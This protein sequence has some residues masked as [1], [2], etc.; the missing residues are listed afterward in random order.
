MSFHPRKVGEG[1]VVREFRDEDVDDIMEMYSL[2]KWPIS[3]EGMKSWSRKSEYTRVLVAERNGKAVGKVTFD[4]AYP[5]YSELVNLVVHPNYRRIGIG[6]RLIQSC[7][8]VAHRKR[9]SIISAMANPANH[10]AHRLYSKFGF[11]I[12]ILPDSKEGKMWLFRF[13]E[14]PPLGKFLF[15]HP[16]SQ[17]SVSPHKILFHDHPLYEMKWIDPMT[18]D[19]MILYLEGQPGQPREGGTMPRIAGI[20]YKEGDMAL[21]C[22]VHEKQKLI[23]L[24]RE[25]LFDLRIVNAG[26]KDLRVEGLEFTL[27][28]GSKVL[29]KK[30][31]PRKLRTGESK[32]VKLKFKLLSNFD[33]PTLSF[34]TILATSCLKFVGTETR[35]VIT[36]GF[37]RVYN[38]DLP[39][40]R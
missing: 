40:K 2:M 24:E 33:V 39:H 9:C 34:G 32:T 20:S 31:I 4:T 29:P 10:S 19:E 38:A 15:T 36:A 27:P 22:V 1:V 18:E 14:D 7:I 8:E 25:A 6:S 35:F 5:P 12:G 37:E 16:F 3:V 28:K 11:H 23:G 21:D 26:R 30:T 13:S 17:P